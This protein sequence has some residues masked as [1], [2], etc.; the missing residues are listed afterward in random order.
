MDEW[1]QAGYN[2]QRSIILHLHRQ[3][4]GLMPEGAPAPR[5]WSQARL[6][7]AYHRHLSDAEAFGHRA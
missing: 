4:K 2:L 3:T 1:G 7:P 5:F 6:E